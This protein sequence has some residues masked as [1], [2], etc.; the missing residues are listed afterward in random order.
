MTPLLLRLLVQGVVLAHHSLRVPDGLD[1]VGQASAVLA[2]VAAGQRAGGWDLCAGGS[3]SFLERGQEGLDGLGGQILVVVVVNLD[4]GGVDA[5]A[6]A[7]DL[8]VGEEAVLGGVAGGDAE[9]LVDGLDNGVTAAAA[10]LA[11]GLWESQSLDSG[12]RK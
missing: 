10:E 8:D 4:H 7:L 6:E 12:D 1:Q 3:G 2:G 11:R 5:S 9:V